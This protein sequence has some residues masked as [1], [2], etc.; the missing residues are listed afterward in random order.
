[1]SHIPQPTGSA[2]SDTEF[3]GN[4]PSKAQSTIAPIENPIPSTNEVSKAIGEH[5]GLLSPWFYQQWRRVTTLEWTTNDPVGKMLWSTEISP[6]SF[7]PTLAWQMAMFHAWGGDF[8]I[9]F[10][11]VATGFHAGQIAV[12]SF[13][14]RID[15][16]DNN[17]PINYTIFPYEIIDVKKLETTEFRLLDRRNTKFHY[18][19]H[20]AKAQLD[21]DIGGRVAIYVDSPLSTSATGVQK[22][23]LCVWVRCAPNFRPEF[24]R[25][26]LEDVPINK[27]SVP[28]TFIDVLNAATDETAL[29][30]GVALVGNLQIQPDTISK[31]TRYY[32]NTCNING[33][34]IDLVGNYPTVFTG[35]RNPIGATYT[36]GNAF[37]FK[38]SDFYSSYIPESCSPFVYFSTAK[39][40]IYPCE[41]T[42]ASGRI[43]AVK[44][45]GS[46]TPTPGTSYAMYM[47]NIEEAYVQNNFSLNN[48][49][50][51]KKGEGFVLFKSSRQ[52]FCTQFLTLSQLL[53]AGILKGT[54][55]PG[56][57]FL[58]QV[59]SKMTKLPLFHM[60][61]HY[62]GYFTAP[63]T[64]NYQLF[65][66]SD[67]IF[68]QNGIINV[69]DSFPDIQQSAANI[70][71][72][73][74]LV[75]HSQKQ[76]RKAL[77]AS[78]NVTE[79]QE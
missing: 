69:L 76:A 78:S 67:I 64:A 2:E 52:F 7:D 45:L 55:S 58:I 66:I 26:P 36:S 65:S 20:D 33:E 61:F 8:E 63:A 57:C 24:V 79:K 29:S 75:H 70:A 16:R 39:D 38:S 42:S 21:E 15:P 35:N 27:A 49:T 60:K 37:S 3:S 77:K 18:I 50:I 40:V 51:V 68:E 53:N 5:M 11:A 46:W 9:C 44:T 41:I 10:R 12:V 19:R 13:P 28:Q 1:M 72:H 56:E 62:N 48:P 17:N 74:F 22:I 59:K 54:L 14:P 73:L 4:H 34:V 30:N 43:V 32:S 25:S 71:T 23:A 31:L 6:L 47:R